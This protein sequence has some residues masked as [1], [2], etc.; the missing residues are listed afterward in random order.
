MLDGVILAVEE[1]IAKGFTIDGNVVVLEVVSADDK[2]DPAT[3]KAVAQQL[4]DA[5]VVAVIANFNSGVSIEAAPFYAA[6]DATQ[7]AISTH[8]TFAHL[9]FKATLRKL[10]NGD[11]E[12]KAMGSYAAR[13]PDAIRFAV[14]DDGTKCRK[15]LADGAAKQRELLKKEAVVRES[16]DDQT[17]AFDGLAAQLKSGKVDVIISMLNDFQTVALLKA[18]LKIDHTQV[19]LLGGDVIK[20]PVVA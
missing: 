18:L 14:I 5:G 13:I 20:T 6:H 17:A 2:S 3:G 15:D 4:V 19:H 7:I 16:L 12:A 1:L 10:A 11:L 9:G 8:P